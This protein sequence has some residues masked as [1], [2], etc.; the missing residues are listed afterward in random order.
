MQVRKLLLIYSSTSLSST[1]WGT[2]LLGMVAAFM[3][4]DYF[5]FMEHVHG[6]VTWDRVSTKRRPFACGKP[7]SLDKT[8]ANDTF[9]PIC[10]SGF[11]GWCNFAVLHSSPLLGVYVGFD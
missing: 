7:R 4:G 6:A 5:P 10:Q 11:V 9:I 1:L 8:F 3:D 2:N